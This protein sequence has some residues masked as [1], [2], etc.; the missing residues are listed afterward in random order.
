MKEKEPKKHMSKKKIVGI[1]LFS[2]IVIGVVYIFIFDTMPQIERKAKI[3]AE[4]E[5]YDKQRSTDFVYNKD[6][7]TTYNKVTVCP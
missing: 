7:C 2:L 1:A 6:E 3:D 4:Y 5:A